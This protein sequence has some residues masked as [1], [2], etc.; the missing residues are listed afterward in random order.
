M[1]FAGLSR[2]FSGGTK[3]TD[4]T[5]ADLTNSKSIFEDENEDEDDIFGDMF[6]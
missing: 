2:G 3:E 5:V 1:Q 4:L 6:N